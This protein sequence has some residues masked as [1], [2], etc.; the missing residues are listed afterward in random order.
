MTEPDEAQKWLADQADRDWLEDDDYEPSARPETVSELD[1][2]ARTFAELAIKCGKTA[3]FLEEVREEAIDVAEHAY[4]IGYRAG[5]AASAERIKVLEEALAKANKPRWFYADDEGSPFDSVHEAVEWILDE[6]GPD[7]DFPNGKG[8]R[9]IDTM[10]DCA[11]I[12]AAVRCRRITEAE[13]AG[14]RKGDFVFDVTEC[15]TYAEAEA[16]LKEADQ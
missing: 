7:D 12:F 13:R 5:Q 1:D 3:A 2:N 15:A 10:R 8:V 14:G 4:K 6:F 11:P 16:L 9:R